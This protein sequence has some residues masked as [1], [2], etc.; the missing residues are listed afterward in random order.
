MN[1]Y[2]IKLVK[3]HCQNCGKI[4]I[5]DHDG[6]SRFINKGRPVPAIAELG[7]SAV[8]DLKQRLGSVTVIEKDEDI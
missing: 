2:S 1:E 4:K 3:P 8:N 5:K 7:K 6:K